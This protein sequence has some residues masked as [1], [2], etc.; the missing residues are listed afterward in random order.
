MRN[1]PPGLKDLWKFR[2]A[3]KSENMGCRGGVRLI[4]VRTDGG[5]EGVC[6]YTKAEFEGQPP[7]GNLMDWSNRL[8]RESSEAGPC[9]E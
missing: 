3:L 1:K 8:P 7:W 9:N 2:I 5:L 4:A 6:L